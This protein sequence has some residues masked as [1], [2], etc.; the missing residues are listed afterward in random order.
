MSAYYSA[1]QSYSR[2]RNAEVAES[3]GRCPMGR[4]KGS[5]PS[6][7]AAPRPSPP[8]PWSCWL[9]ANGIMSVNSRLTLIITTPPTHASSARRGTS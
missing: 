7:S 3:E 1:N 8:S 9:T 6:G 4:A 2:S 5:S